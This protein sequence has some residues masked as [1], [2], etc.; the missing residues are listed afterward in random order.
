[1]CIQR[2]MRSKQLKAWESEYRS[3]ARI[4][5]GAPPTLPSL[6]EG[7]RILELGCGNGKTLSAMLE[8]SWKVTALDIS[9]QALRLSMDL[10]AEL[11][12]ASSVVDFIM[13]DASCLPFQDSSFDAV[14]SYHIMGHSLLD[15]RFKIAF[16]ASRV[17]KAGG[18]LFFLDFEPH[19]MRAWQG[20]SVETNTFLRGNGIL[21]HYFSEEEIFELFAV[22]RPVSMKTKNRK[23]RI[24]GKDHLR[25]HIEAVFV[26]DGADIL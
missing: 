9:R 12:K 8:R 5:S 19:D 24:M 25:S 11:R 20:D 18:H 7:S 6:P 15:Q 2:V 14:F 17:L 13:A 4:W 10:K 26:K 3:R 1:M 23:M 16:E 22:L 21:T